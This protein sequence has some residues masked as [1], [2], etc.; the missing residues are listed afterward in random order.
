MMFFIGSYARDLHFGNKIYNDLDTSCEMSDIYTNILI[1]IIAAFVVF[2]LLLII[3]AKLEQLFPKSKTVK[4]ISKVIEA[5]AH[6]VGRFS[7]V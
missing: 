2:F 6:I 1:S 5:I 3:S 7:V 4:K